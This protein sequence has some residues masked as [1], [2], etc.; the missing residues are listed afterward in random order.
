MSLDEYRNF[1]KTVFDG[2]DSDAYSRNELEYLR[3]Q[4]E[5]AKELY[6]LENEN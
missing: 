3:L 1:L 4:F 5:I 2:L 6:R